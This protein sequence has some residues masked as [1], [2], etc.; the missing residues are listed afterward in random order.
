[1]NVVGNLVAL[2]LQWDLC[3]RWISDAGNS[4]LM[5]LCDVASLIRLSITFVVC[6]LHAAGKHSLTKVIETATGAAL[7][8]AIIT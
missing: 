8:G 6:E 7:A 4:S 3:E 5:L 1:Q 2:K